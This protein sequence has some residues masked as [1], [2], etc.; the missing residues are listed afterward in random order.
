MQIIYYSVN[1]SPSIV[2][3]V[4]GVPWLKIKDEACSVPTLM[5]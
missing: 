5:V 1:F 4:L 3:T 2:I